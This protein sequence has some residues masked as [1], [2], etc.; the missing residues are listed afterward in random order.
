M[1]KLDVYFIRKINPDIELPNL[2]QL[3]TKSASLS[4][5][6]GNGLSIA[7][8]FLPMVAGFLIGFGFYIILMSV[9]VLNRYASFSISFVAALIV[10]QFTKSYLLACEI[11]RYLSL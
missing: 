7:K 1:N 10:V 3:I 2:D 9:F 8:I 5:R 11:R 6:K 4:S